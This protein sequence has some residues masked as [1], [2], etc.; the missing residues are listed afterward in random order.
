MCLNMT[1]TVPKLT[2]ANTINECMKE[3]DFCSGFAFQ[4]GNV[5]V[6]VTAAATTTN[7]SQQC[8]LVLETFTPNTCSK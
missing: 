1:F 2:I 7:S 5:V 6:P 4:S 8:G 3:F